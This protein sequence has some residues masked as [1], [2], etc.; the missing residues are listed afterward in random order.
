MF[1]PKLVPSS[2]EGISSAPAEPHITLVLATTTTHQGR[3]NELL[4]CLLP[5]KC[6][7]AT[8]HR[9]T[10]HT[11]FLPRLARPSSVDRIESAERP[12]QSA[13]STLLSFLTN[14]SAC[15]IFSVYFL[16]LPSAFYIEQ[17][18]FP[19]TNNVA[20]FHRRRHCTA[21]W[22]CGFLY[23]FPRSFPRTEAIACQQ[24]TLCNDAGT[25]HV[26]QEQ[27]WR[28]GAPTVTTNGC[29]CSRRDRYR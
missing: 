10:S 14:R 15:P 23:E 9:T 5:T 2:V 27:E 21:R 29:R 16:A 4:C 13:P 11:H 25:A 7:P 28:H 6:R 20:L 18:F 24:Q 17:T 3:T 8:A 22:M 1:S 12:C 26:H 19:S